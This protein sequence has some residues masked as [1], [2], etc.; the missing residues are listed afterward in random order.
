M[1]AQ[2]ANDKAVT[3]TLS[4]P[5]WR[6][7]APSNNVSYQWKKP[8]RL[9][10]SLWG[11]EMLSPMFPL[12]GCVTSLCRTLPTYTVQDVAVHVKENIYQHSC[13][14]CT[15]QQQPLV[16]CASGGFLAAQHPL[17]SPTSN[18]SNLP[19]GTQG[20]SQRLKSVPKEIFYFLVGPCLCNGLSCPCLEPEYTK[21]LRSVPFLSHSQSKGREGPIEIQ[22]CLE[23]LHKWA[24]FFSFRGDKQAKLV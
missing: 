9:V 21:V 23:K 17:P 1:L 22:S 6:V 15:C 20:R 4:G 3:W 24:S 2:E 19:F 11:I 18:C 16:G 14:N 12:L 10:Q 5:R 13:W 8:K 7:K